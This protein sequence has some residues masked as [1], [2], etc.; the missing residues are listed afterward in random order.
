MQFG[1]GSNKNLK[2]TI[3]RDMVWKNKS[4]HIFLLK[5]IKK[6]SSENK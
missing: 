1:R 4:H 2:D 6:I 3:I 5:V